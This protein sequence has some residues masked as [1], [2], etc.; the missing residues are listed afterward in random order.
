M[1]VLKP[2]I[3]IVDINMP[4][5]DGLEFVQNIRQTKN[6]SKIIILTGHSEFNYAKQAVQLGVHTYLLKPV[7][8]DELK[9]TLLELKNIIDKEVKIK[10]EMDKLKQQARD[11]IP[12]LKDKFLNE[13]LQ[14]NIISDDGT[15]KKMEYLKVNSSSDYYLSVTIELDTDEHFSWS[16]E[17]KQLWKFAVSNIADEILSEQF[18]FDRCYDN[19]DRICFIIGKYE[20][21]DRE[22]FLCNLDNK[23]EWLREIVGKHMDFSITIGVGEIRNELFDVAT[24]YKESIVALK[25][26]VTLGKDK[27]ILYSSVADSEININLLMRAIL[28]ELNIKC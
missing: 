2:E 24:S 20:S 7:D 16:D 17:D 8:E 3:I 1:G 18:N 11:S 21:E 22:K 27:V 9:K 15:L 6:D 19:E 26:K 12:L 28:A 13:L 23:L 10:M 4:I 14:G 5:M 25:N